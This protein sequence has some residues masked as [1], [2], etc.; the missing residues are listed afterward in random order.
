MTDREMLELAAKAAGI[1]ITPHPNAKI[2]RNLI[3]TA[4]GLQ[5]YY[6]PSAEDIAKLL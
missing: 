6:R 5:R 2:A 4:G 1:E 3:F